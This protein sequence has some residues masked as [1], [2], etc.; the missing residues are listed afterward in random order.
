[1]LN[2]IISIFPNIPEHDLSELLN[3]IKQSE[4]FANHFNQQ[5]PT[6]N[7]ELSYAKYLAK[8]NDLFLNEYYDIVLEGCFREF[9][10]WYEYITKN[11]LRHDVQ[12]ELG[13]TLDPSDS[14]WVKKVQESEVFGWAIQVRDTNVFMDNIHKVSK[15][16]SIMQSF[17]N[18]RKPMSTMDDDYFESDHA[19]LVLDSIDKI[20]IGNDMAELKHHAESDKLMCM[21]EVYGWEN[22]FNPILLRWFY[23]NKDRLSSW[24]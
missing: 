4:Q 5:T 18:A 10:E 14:D 9:L 22:R 12:E 19:Q 2:K 24:I 20:L 23:E 8:P 21:I 17:F 3:V 16:G 7:F 13:Y 15:L 6:N 11:I 1:M